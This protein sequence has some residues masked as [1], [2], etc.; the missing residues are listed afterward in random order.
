MKMVTGSRNF[1]LAGLWVIFGSD[2]INFRFKNQLDRQRDSQGNGAWYRAYRDTS[3]K[4]DTLPGI[5][6]GWK[7]SF[8]GTI[9]NIFRADFCAFVALDTLFFIDYRW[10]DGSP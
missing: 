9:E 5:G 7:L 8:F 1:P 4:M 2:R 10:H 6:Y 3:I